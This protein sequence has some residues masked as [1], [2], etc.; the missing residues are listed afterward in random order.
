MRI[1]L[2]AV[3]VVFNNQQKKAQSFYLHSYITL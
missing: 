1:F 2:I 3:T